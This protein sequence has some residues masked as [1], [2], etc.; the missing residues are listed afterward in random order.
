M[1]HLQNKSNVLEF[2]ISQ[3][4]KHVLYNEKISYVDKYAHA[5]L[6][7]KCSMDMECLRGRI[8]HEYFM[9]LVKQELDNIQYD[10]NIRRCQR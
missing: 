5:R 9:V 4:I 10:Y 2:E 1:M 3:T 8:N 7:N 6:F